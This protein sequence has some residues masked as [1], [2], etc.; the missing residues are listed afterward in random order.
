[1]RT[2][3]WVWTDNGVGTIEFIVRDE[4]MEGEISCVCSANEATASVE[5]VITG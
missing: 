2:K 4:M 3:V 5:G 1:M